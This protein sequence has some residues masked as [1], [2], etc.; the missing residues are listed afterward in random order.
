MRAILSE[1]VGLKN[2]AEL[3]YM[4]VKTVI[5]D[6]TVQPIERPRKDQKLY[7][8]GAK[9]H[10]IKPQLIVNQRDKTIK[11]CRV[12]LEG[13]KSDIR[14]FRK[15]PL[16]IHRK[17]KVNGDLG[18]VGIH[19]THARSKM[20]HK[21]PKNEE[22]TKKDKTRRLAVSASEL[23]TST[24]YVNASELLKKRTTTA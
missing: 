3:R 10:V 19:K 12:E 14:I 24:G 22:L 16:T 8:N 13:R 2:P 5:V 7:Y 6:V 4:D 1:V 11:Y 20:P 23:N 9:K 17:I 18:Y 21:K 15:T